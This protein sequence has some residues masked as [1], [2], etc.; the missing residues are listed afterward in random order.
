[1]FCPKC[2]VHAGPDAS[3]FCRNCGFRL[4]GVLQLLA[5]NGAPDGTVQYLPAASQIASPRKTG[6]RQGAKILFSSVV[7]FPLMLGLAIGIDSPAPL[8]FPSFLFFA[9]LMRMLY[10]RL[11]ADDFQT[12]QPSPQPVVFYPPVVSALPGMY[13]PPA[14]QDLLPESVPTTGNLVEPTSV[15]EQTTN[16]LNRK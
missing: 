15:T 13:Q 11:F 3:R 14:G 12:S 9:G 4:D 10:A 5:R 7:L 8:I 16:L 6:I 1:M 2:G